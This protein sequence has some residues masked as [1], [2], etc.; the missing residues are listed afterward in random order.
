MQ[1]QSVIV[2]ALA[3]TVQR[4]H[5][6]SFPACSP[7]CWERVVPCSSPL[8]RD[9]AYAAMAADPV[10][11]LSTLREKKLQA[12]SAAWNLPL[13]RQATPHSALPQVVRYPTPRTSTFPSNRFNSRSPH[14]RLPVIRPANP[15]HDR[16]IDSC[17]LSR[18]L[19]RYHR[20]VV[21]TPP[22]RW[23][24]ATRQSHLRGLPAC[25]PA[26]TDSVVACSR[27]LRDILQV[28]CPSWMRSRDSR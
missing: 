22:S 15:G 18:Q 28:D 10:L 21:C 8:N 24:P 26:I 20:H 17:C 2:S 4:A 19:L 23:P 16:V 1:A 9:P 5:Q 3:R 7:D 13:A 11:L 6:D 12:W 25:T 27:L 14:P